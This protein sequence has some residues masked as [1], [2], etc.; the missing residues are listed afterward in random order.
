MLIIGLT[1]G[2][3]SGKSSVAALFGKYDIPV[4]DADLI[5]RELVDVGKPAYHAILEHFGKDICQPNQQI[6][7]SKLRD[8]IFSNPA[9]RRWLEALLH[10]LVKDELAAQLQTLTAPYCIVMIPLLIET[11]PYP[12]LDRILVVDVNPEQQMLRTMARDQ[13]S[14]E[15]IDEIINTQVSREKRLTYADDVIHNDGSFEMLATQV[16]YLHKFYLEL[17]QKKSI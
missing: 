13:L 5:A 14:R 6:N 1:G 4:L 9:K 15:K 3:G 16:Q 7:R 10:P 2:L 11:L 8:T 12:Y 17:S